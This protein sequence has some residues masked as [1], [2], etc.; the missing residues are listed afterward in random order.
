MDTITTD[1]RALEVEFPTAKIGA[2]VHGVDLRDELSETC[3]EELRAVLADREVLFL[4]DQEIQP[5]DHLRF[6]RVFGE[7][8]SV[9]FFFPRLEDSEFIQVLESHGE[10]SGTDIWHTDHSWQRRPP[11]ATCLHAQVLPPVGGDTVW[12]SMTAAYASLSPTMQEL[13]ADLPRRP[14]VGEVDRRLH[15]TGRRWGGAL[16]QAKGSLPAG[17]TQGGADASR[18]GEARAVRQRELHHHDQG[19]TS[20]RREHAPR[21]PGRA[22]QGS[23]A[24]GSPPLAAQHAGD[25]GQPLDPA[26]RGERLRGRPPTLASHHGGGCRSKFPRRLRRLTRPTDVVLA[27]GRNPVGSTSR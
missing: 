11:V 18:H 21:V 10:S 8:R 12:A 19:H 24:P 9:S 13:V 2:I 4:H 27:T 22:G 26:L 1:Y 23:R 16:P 14:H 7:P 20:D 3:R 15:P 25:M 17:R 6:A 5:A